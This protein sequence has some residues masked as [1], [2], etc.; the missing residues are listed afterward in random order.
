MSKA[1]DIYAKSEHLLGIEESTRVLHSIFIVLLEDEQVGTLLDVGCGRGGLLEEAL[2]SGISAKGIDLSEV[3][4]RDAC[5]KGLDVTCKNICEVTERFGAVTAVFDVL[6]FIADEE[7]EAFF[8]C[9][10]DVLEE[11]G[12]FLADINTQYGF[13]DVAEGTMSAE[14][15]KMFLNVNAVFEENKLYT[16]FTL[17]EKLQNNTYAKSQETI[18]QHYHDLERLRNN[19]TLKLIEDHPLSLYD[20]DDKMMLIFKKES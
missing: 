14:D 3:M 17:F 5:E 6:N 2:A 15:E 11:G 18:V 13:S 12:L 20:V 8:R 9:V 4:V 1:L 10:G 7:L 16:E 19:G